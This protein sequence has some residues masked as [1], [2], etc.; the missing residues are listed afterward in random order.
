MWL[1]T[2]QG[3]YS[4]VESKTD[5]N[6]IVVRAR[7]RRDIEALERQIPGAKK[8]IRDDLGTDYPFR[9]FVDR[10]TWREAVVALTEAIDYT[11][12]KD[13][14]K[15]RQGKK[16]ASLYERLWGILFGLTPPRQRR[17]ASRLD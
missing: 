14:V 9:I 8:M 5:P 12:F 1:V 4:A 3:F 15:A 17:W 11:N 7:V 2:T 13:E 6:M 16:R 10:A